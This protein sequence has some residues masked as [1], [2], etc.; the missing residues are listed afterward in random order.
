MEIIEVRTPGMTP[1]QCLFGPDYWVAVLQDGG[2][3]AGPLE[4][5]TDE[6]AEAEVREHDGA[7]LVVRVWHCAYNIA[8]TPQAVADWVLE[9]ASRDAGVP[10]ALAGGPSHG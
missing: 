9:A 8:P 3:L 2:L 7:S 4:A 1:A 5:K 10:Y 6:A